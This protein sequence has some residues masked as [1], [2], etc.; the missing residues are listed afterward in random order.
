MPVAVI[1]KK[2]EIIK[3]LA[4]W[5]TDFHKAFYYK[6]LIR[7]DCS[8]R[9]F[10]WDGH[11]VWGLD[12]EDCRKG[13][14]VE[15]VADA[16]S[17]VL[18]SSPEFTE[19]KVDLCRLLILKYKEL[20]PITSLEDVAE[21]TAVALESKA[22]WREDKGELAAAAEAIREGGIAAAARLNRG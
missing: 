20:A 10:M 16:C 5:L 18:A 12:L 14:P 21:E 6:K 3:S 1:G 9:N 19:E 4:G 22:Q 11:F 7:G 15:D 2:N 17:S 13:R 8:L